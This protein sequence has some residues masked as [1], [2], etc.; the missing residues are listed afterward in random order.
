MGWSTSAISGSIGLKLVLLRFRASAGSGAFWTLC[1]YSGIIL[2]AIGRRPKL[3]VKSKRYKAVSHVTIIGIRDGLSGA[4]Q[5]VFAQSTNSVKRWKMIPFLLFPFL[6]LAL[7]PLDLPKILTQKTFDSRGRAVAANYFMAMG[8]EGAAKKIAFLATNAGSNR[9]R[10]HWKHRLG[11]M[12]RILYEPKGK[13]PLRMGGFGSPFIPYRTMPLEQ[14]PH[15][16]LVLSGDTYFVLVEGYGTTGRPETLVRYL[17]YCR[18]EGNFR[19]TPVALPDRKKALEDFA[20][21]T[22]SD[23]WKA[24][25]WHE[26]EGS[27]TYSFSEQGALARLKAQAEN[28]PEK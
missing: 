9:L 4:T 1:P 7:P 13:E 24:I 6:G 5:E 26:S 10:T 16:P 19:K 15:F 3:V 23:S 20:L 17:N 21:L 8:E 11:W 18:Q 22:N 12:C 14:W 28:I 25:K 27:P 2:L